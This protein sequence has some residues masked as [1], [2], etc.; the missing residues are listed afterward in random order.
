MNQNLL[1]LVRRFVL[2]SCNERAPGLA[3]DAFAVEWDG[4]QEGTE[5]RSIKI[6][7]S[8]SV[9]TAFLALKF[10]LLRRKNETVVVGEC[11]TGLRF[12]LMLCTAKKK[13]DSKIQI[14]TRYKFDF[15]LRCLAIVSDGRF[16]NESGGRRVVWGDREFYATVFR[17][18]CDCWREG[19][20][21][22]NGRCFPD[23]FSSQMS[24]ASR[25]HERWKRLK[26]R[27]RVQCFVSRMENVIDIFLPF[28]VSSP[29]RGGM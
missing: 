3:C 16:V 22:Q 29:K 27:A 14:Q 5:L 12:R 24:Q 20:A 2:W 13:N 17:S 10:N 6:V 21:K 23:E 1:P 11:A 18:L 7:K 19:D 8:C 9:M 26:A 25:R 28:A 15:L 4:K